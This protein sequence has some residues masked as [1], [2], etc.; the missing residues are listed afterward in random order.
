MPRSAKSLQ[1]ASF[2]AAALEGLDLQRKRIEE[3]IAQVRAMLGGKKVSVG[4][5]AAPAKPAR[6][7]VLSSA[8]RRRIAAAQKKRWAEYRRKQA[9]QAKVA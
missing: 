3:Q 8:A 6:K 1:N 4:A 7:R 2:L 5:S 9:A